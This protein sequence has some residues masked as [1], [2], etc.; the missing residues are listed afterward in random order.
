[1]AGLAV[2]KLLTGAILQEVREH[3][4]KDRTTL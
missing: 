4:G 1:M 3:C 2:E